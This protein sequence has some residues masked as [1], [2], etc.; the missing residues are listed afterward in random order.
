MSLPFIHSSFRCCQNLKLIALISFWFSVTFLSIK[1]G[2]TIWNIHIDL[3]VFCTATNYRW[4]CFTLI[5]A[6]QY[7]LVLVQTSRQKQYMVPTIRVIPQKQFIIRN[8][9][10][11]FSNNVCPHNALRRRGKEKTNYFCDILRPVI[12][13]LASTESNA[14]L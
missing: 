1:Q 12:F 9:F 14:P 6:P 3:H 4:V 13:W 10:H 2:C 8:M 7:S 11:G 5:K